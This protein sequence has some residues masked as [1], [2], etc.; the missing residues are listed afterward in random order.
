MKRMIVYTFLLGSLCL[1][2][3][4]CSSSRKVVEK[5]PIDMYVMPCSDLVSGNGVLRAWASGTS[6]NETVARKKAQTAASAELA[7]MLE[8]AV[9]ST[10]EDYTT[11]L[12]EGLVSESKSFF[13]EKT[14]VVVNQTLKGATVVC[15][16]WAKDE[17]T[18]QYTNYIVMELRGADYLK[19]LNEELSKDSIHLVNEELLEEL[20]LKH[21]DD[22]DKDK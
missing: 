7:A 4:G 14:K 3:T 22:I 12:A 2:S 9:T 15:E 17:A 1:F 11:A 21:I 10:T 19:E 13:S 20:F 6:D 16:R 18:G 8:K 5:T